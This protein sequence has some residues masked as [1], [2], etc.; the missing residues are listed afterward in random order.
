MTGYR[1]HPET[2]DDLEEIRG[3]IAADNPDASNRVITE[4]FDAIRA[5]VSFPHRG[6]RRTDLTSRP[7]RFMR[8]RDYLIPYAP[9]EKQLWVIAVMHGHRSPR[10]M[11]A[12]LRGRQDRPLS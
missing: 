7:V 6:Y 8:V 11:A 12:V 2:Y 9:D 4:I 1:L 3:Y 5:L 10:V